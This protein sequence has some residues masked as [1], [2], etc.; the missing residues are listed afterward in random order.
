M[1]YSDT[2]Q[3]GTDIQGMQGKH[4]V[5]DWAQISTKDEKENDRD[6]KFSVCTLYS[7]DC[8]EPWSSVGSNQVIIPICAGLQVNIIRR[9]GHICL[10]SWFLKCQDSLM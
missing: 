4:I 9:Q 8:S 2:I 5:I 1:C 10:T 6:I 3:D 7:A